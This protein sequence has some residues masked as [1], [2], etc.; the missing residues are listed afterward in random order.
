MADCDAMIHT[1]M[2]AMGHC[3][4]P[5]HIE[6]E[7]GELTQHNETTD[8]FFKYSRLNV[9]FS[10]DWFKNH[11]G[12]D[13]DV[14]RLQHLSRIDEPNAIDELLEIGERAAGKASGFRSISLKVN[15][16]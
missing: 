1:T 5:A 3:D 6:S 16:E 14:E 2:K 9:E 8:N 7:F 15:R 4:S 12:M 11:L 10:T 13:M